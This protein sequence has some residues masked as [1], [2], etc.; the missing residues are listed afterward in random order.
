MLRRFLLTLLLALGFVVPAQAVTLLTTP[1]TTAVAAQVSAVFQIRGVGAG[2]TPSSVAVQGTVAGTAG[3]SMQ[4]WLQTSFD[5]GTTWCDAI[6]GF[7]AAA[8]RLAG[9]VLSNPTAGAV[10]AACTDGTQ[11]VGASAVQNGIYAGLWRVKYT[12]V[13][14][15][16]TGNL[17]IDVFGNGIVPAQ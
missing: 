6:T 16:T 17:R 4:W 7:H 2:V 5:G 15:W 10:P 14:T 1:V 9:I 13:G 3:T 11:S 8:G 12:T